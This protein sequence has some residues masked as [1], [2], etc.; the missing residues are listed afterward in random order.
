MSQDGVGVTMALSM[1]AVGACASVDPRP[2]VPPQ[3][4]FYQ[5]SKIIVPTG[6]TGVLTSTDGCVRFVQQAGVRAVQFPEGTAYSSAD[7]AVVLP[8]G[9]KLRFGRR[10]ELAFEAIPNARSV[11][12]ACRGLTAIQIMR[13]SI[14]L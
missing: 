12:P 14:R 13:R 1:L 4:E 5:P 3:I 11:V 6:A 2:A 7:A 10:L 9:E 8:N